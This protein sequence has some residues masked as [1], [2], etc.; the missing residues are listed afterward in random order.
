MVRSAHA[1]TQ[2]T[3]HFRTSLKS[4]LVHLRLLD[5][6]WKKEAA[7]SPAFAK[8]INFQAQ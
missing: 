1:R 5:A 4:S 2:G 8:S 7:N 6:F 3:L